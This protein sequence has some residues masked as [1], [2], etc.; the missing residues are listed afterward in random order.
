MVRYLR[1]SSRK[2]ISNFQKQKSKLWTFTYANNTRAQLDHT[3][4]N[5]K[6]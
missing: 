1:I 2:T 6:S 3:L 4:I 5:K